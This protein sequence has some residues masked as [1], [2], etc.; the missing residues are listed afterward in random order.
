MNAALILAPGADDPT[1]LVARLGLAGVPVLALGVP[2]AG[3]TATIPAAGLT[4]RS[5]LLA[6]RAVGAD[7]ARSWLAAADPALLGVAATAGLAGLVLIGVEPPVGDH[8]LVVARADNLAD[9]PRVMV[10][11]GGG[12]WHD[13]R[14]AG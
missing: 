4:A 14:N 7:P 9:V 5:V 8:P 11:R 1:A 3:C 12:C 13:H 10:P 6:L 2:F